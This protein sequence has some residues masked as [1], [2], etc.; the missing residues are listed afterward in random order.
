[1]LGSVPVSP[2]KTLIG[3]CDPLSV[4]PGDGVAFKVSCY[5]PGPYRADIVRVIC[6]DASSRGAGFEEREVTTAVSGEYAGLVALAERDLADF[7]AAL[8][9]TLHV[10]RRGGAAFVIT[11]GARRAARLGLT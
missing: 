8:G 6:G 9:E 7:D 4:R 1:M 3:Y 5:A 2:R 11:Y 10:L